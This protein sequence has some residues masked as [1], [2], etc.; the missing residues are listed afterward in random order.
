MSCRWF[1]GHVVNMLSGSQWFRE[2]FELLIGRAV[3]LL[4]SG[5]L[6]KHSALFYCGR[7]GAAMRPDATNCSLASVDDGAGTAAAGTR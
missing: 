5:A 7:P 2:R 3:L 6:P 4:A 1:C